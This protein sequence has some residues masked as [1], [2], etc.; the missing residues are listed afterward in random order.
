MEITWLAEPGLPRHVRINVDGELKKKVSLSIVSLRELKALPRDENFFHTLHDL[1]ERGGIRYSLYS[2]S[3]QSLHSKKLEKALSRHFL[4]KDIIAYV[5]DHCHKLSLFDDSGWIERR[6]HRWQAQGKSS[7]DIKARLMKEGV[8]S[9]DIVFDDSG[10]LEGLVT[11]KYPQLLN[12]RTSFKERMR[13][14]QSIRRRGF[15]FHIVQ[16][17]LQKKELTAMMGEEIAEE[18]LF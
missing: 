9:R 14:L 3:R 13:A 4:E 12:P 2:L 1:E 8:S 18:E 17:F 6:V 7:A 11:R 5:I 15:S 10:S 16:E